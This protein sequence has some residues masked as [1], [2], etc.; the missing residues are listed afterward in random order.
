MAMDFNGLIIIVVYVFIAIAVLAFI[1]PVIEI[2]I[3]WIRNKK[4]SFIERA[5]DAHVALYRKRKKMSVENIKD[6]RIRKLVLLGDEDFY[7]SSNYGRVR[8]IYWKNEIVECFVQTRKLRPWVWTKIP[9]ELVRDALSTCLR[10]EANG[11]EPLGNF[12]KPLY[13]KSVRG[14]TIKVKRKVVLPNP[15][16]VWIEEELPLSVYYDSLVLGHE[17]YLMLV[18]KSV[19][20]EEQKVHAMIDAVDTKRRAD[21]LITRPDYA[22]AVPGAAEEGP[23]Y[24]KE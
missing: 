6:T 19:E 5:D 1:M 18:E 23:Q 22:P 17:E 9:K 10:V 4:K 11:F 3:W 16:E 15:G 14:K 8:G 7:D 20:A 24:D 12:A 2:I 13:T 21:A